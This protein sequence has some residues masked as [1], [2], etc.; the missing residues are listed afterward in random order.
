MF[1]K[2]IIDAAIFHLPVIIV[3]IPLLSAF[4]IPIVNKISKILRDIV[5]FIATLTNFILCLLLASHIYQNGPLAYVL[6]GSKTS[7]LM[8]SG[9]S[10][11]IRIILN[12]DGL[13]ILLALVFSLIALAIIL[14]SLSFINKTEKL[15]KFYS[16]FM[17]SLAGI[18]GL[19]FTADLFNLFVF[20]EIMSIAS[21]GL[22]IY[23]RKE[24]EAP[25][26]AFKY[27]VISTLAALFI[28]FGVGILYGQYASLN[29]AYLSKIIQYTLID[30]IALTFLLTG[31]AMKCGAVPLHMWV[32]D[33]Y[34]R[35]PGPVTP[36]FVIISQTGIYAAVRTT[37][38]LFGIKLNT[39]SIGWIIIILGILSMVIGVLMALPQ[40]DIKRLMAYHAISQTGYM[41][42]GLGVGLAALANTH[43]LNSFG[44]TA[45]NGGIFHII[46]HALYKGLLFL[47]AAAIFY[48]IGTRNLNNMSGLAHYMPLTSIFFI[49]GAFAISGI[50]PFNGFSSKF[51]IY[52][53]VFKF[54]PLLSIIAIVVSILTLAS[55][56]KV[57]CSAFLGPKTEEN[58]DVKEVPVGMALGM[59]VLALLIIVIG[60]FPGFVLEKFIQPAT[61]ALINQANYIGAI[62]P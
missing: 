17:L 53:S 13:N 19:L 8:P 46:N 32:P 47:T 11:P 18:L 7:L 34:S 60:L 57:F 27:L 56:M 45:I 62:L 3:C 31:F 20:F 21:A 49:I 50:P 40:K 15:R 12:I 4:I 48:R 55:F 42:L 44:I 41:L 16:L 54:N 38:T 28:L 36:L 22:I 25:E 39:I 9:K 30:K 35:T 29:I 43:S 2:T 6:G 1:T 24:Y 23:Y 52:E 58:K 33:A 26:S 51:L 59:T 10:I 5:T 14:Y 61:N 37:F